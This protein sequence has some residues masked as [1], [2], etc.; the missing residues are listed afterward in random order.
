MAKMKKKWVVLCSTAIAAVYTAGYWATESDKSNIPVNAVYSSPSATS[1]TSGSGTAQV[2]DSQ[3]QVSSKYND[4][5]YVGM[6]SNR[7]GTIQVS[8]AIEND[9]ITDVEISDFAMHYSI[10][11]VVGMPDEVLQIQS[12]NVENVSGATYS[13]RAFSDAVQDALDQALRA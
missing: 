12:A 5:T 6:G 13:T 1:S 3:S 2:L 11:D 8:V 9:R 10:D 7:R 4:G